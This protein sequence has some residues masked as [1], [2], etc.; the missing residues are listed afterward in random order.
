MVDIKGIQY[1]TMKN[2]LKTKI[3]I[4]FQLIRKDFSSL[5]TNTI[6]AKMNGLELGRTS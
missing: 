4:T 5:N 2:I 3:V 6:S 1:S